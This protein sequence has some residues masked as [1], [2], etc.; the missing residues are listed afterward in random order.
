MQI[1]TNACKSIQMHV[2]MKSIGS[3]WAKIILSQH[4]FIS[5][6]IGLKPV[7][8]INTVMRRVILRLTTIW[9][10]SGLIDFFAYKFH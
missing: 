10:T 9:N 7:R 2:P 1:D 3:I 6:H 8:R 4:I 5:F